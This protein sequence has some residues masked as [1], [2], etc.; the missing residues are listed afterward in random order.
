MLSGTGED[1]QV[2]LLTQYKR[3]M[4][5]QNPPLPPMAHPLPEQPRRAK[6]KKPPVAVDQLIAMIRKRDTDAREGFEKGLR[7]NKPL[8]S[9]SEHELREHAMRVGVPSQQKALQQHDDY[10]RSKFGEESVAFMNTF[11]EL[12]ARSIGRGSPEVHTNH[13]RAFVDFME[14]YFEDSEIQNVIDEFISYRKEPPKLVP[15]P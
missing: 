6:L 14:Q 4:E 12:S 2:P 1:T 8:A 9:S 11:I 5:Q 10:L 15:K 13:W 7:E 3:F